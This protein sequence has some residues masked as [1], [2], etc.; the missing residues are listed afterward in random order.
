MND[1]YKSLREVTV[2]LLLFVGI[3]TIVQAFWASMEIAVYGVPRPNSI[4]TI[5]GLVLSA[6]LYCNLRHYIKIGG[7]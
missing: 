7:T 4:D 2:K 3:S 6:S 1:P 5:V